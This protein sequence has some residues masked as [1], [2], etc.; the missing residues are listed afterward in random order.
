V[1]LAAL[2]LAAP[3]PATD[4]LQEGLASWA[5]KIKGF[6]DEAKQ[7]RVAVGDFTGPP[8]PAT[9]AAPGI[10]QALTSAL[11]AKGVTADPGAEVYLQGQYFWVKDEK[12]RGRDVY[13]LRLEGKLRLRSSG[14]MLGEVD[15]EVRGNVDLV[16]LLGATVSLGSMT[17]ANAGDRNEAVFKHIA[18]KAKETTHLEGTR[19]KAVKGSPYA[20]EV[21]VGDEARPARLVGGQAFAAVRKGEVYALRVHN[22]SP[23]EAAVSVT[24]DG[25]DLFAFSA[26]RD[27]KTGAR[28]TH[29]II[30]PREWGEVVGW[31][32]SRENTASF[33]VTDYKSSALAKA[34]KGA[35]AL[36]GNPRVGTVTV[37][38][39]RSW[40]G[41]KVP[42]DEAGGKDAGGA[43]GF[44]PVKEV[45]TRPVSRNIGV[46]REAVTVRYSKAETAK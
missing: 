19:V 18:G 17:K 13:Y 26:E 15:G 28:P 6:L 37:C 2:L 36:T 29:F 16:R 44:G 41:D 1:S 40:E 43:T 5:G 35:A 27:P 45:K 10:Q 46:L 34:L 14:K 12:A 32:L 22:A 3:A 39:H 9:N 21:L 24:I 31:H 8:S 11:K 23:H 38:F 4:G 42:A 20:V 7:S 33:Q 30:R 25:L